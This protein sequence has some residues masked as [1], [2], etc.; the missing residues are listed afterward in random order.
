MLSEAS[1]FVHLSGVNPPDLP[2]ASHLLLDGTWGNVLVTDNVFGRIRVSPYAFAARIAGLSRGRRHG[3]LPQRRNAQNA[4]GA[5][6]M[7]LR[8]E[9]II[10]EAALAWN[11]AAPE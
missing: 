3:M 9:T 11:Q 6:L 8:F 5:I 4:P 7:G 1:S 10:D 2:D